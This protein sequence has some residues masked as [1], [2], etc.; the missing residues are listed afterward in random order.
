MG[1]VGGSHG[2]C[3]AEVG[4]HLT[5]VLPGSVL[6]NPTWG[7]S[8]G[9]KTSEEAAETA[10]GSNGAWTGVVA[11]LGRCGQIWGSLCSLQARL[12]GTG[13][14]PCTMA[15][16]LGHSTLQC[17]EHSHAPEGEGSTDPGL[18]LVAETV[19]ARQ[20]RVL[21]TGSLQERVQTDSHSLRP[22]R[23]SLR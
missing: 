10:L 16:P 12:G 13:E 22:P 19:R 7:E 18:C 6:I 21:Q 23:L 8:G 1:Q 5:W 2:G 20:G 4:C 14:G 17:T 3:G 9:R 11:M 15:V